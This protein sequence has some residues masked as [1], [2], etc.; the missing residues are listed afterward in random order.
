RDRAHLTVLILGGRDWRGD[1]LTPTDAYVVVTYSGHR[2]RTPTA[3]NTDRP[4]WTDRLDFGH[5]RLHPG[6]HL[7]LQVW[8]EDHGWDDDHLGT[9]VRPLTAGVRPL[10]TCFSGGGRLDFGV[11][12]RCGPALA[13]PWCHDYVPVAPRG[14]AGVQEGSEWPPK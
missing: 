3:W 7:E 9:C 6:A 13:G 2:Q 1:L 10:L 12:V 11:T 5:V 4:L 8:D 14:G